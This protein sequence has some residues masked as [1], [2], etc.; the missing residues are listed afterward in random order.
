MGLRLRLRAG[1][2]VSGFRPVQVM[3]RA[4]KKYGLMVADSGSDW[5]ISGAHDPRWNDDVLH[6]LSMV[7]GSDF[8]AVTTGAIHPY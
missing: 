4:M 5:F 7:V 3:L 6:E 8:E 1:F 2:D